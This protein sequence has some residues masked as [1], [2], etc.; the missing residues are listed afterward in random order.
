MG[1]CLNQL[2]IANMKTLAAIGLPQHPCLRLHRFTRVAR[3]F[4]T[5]D[6]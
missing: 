2:A 5:A 3:V 4:A 6:G 1:T